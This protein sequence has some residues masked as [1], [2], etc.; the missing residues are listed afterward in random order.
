M[1]RFRTFLIIVTLSY[2]VPIASRAWA[3]EATEAPPSAE[4][5]VAP[6]NGL[7]Q[8]SP[9]PTYYPLRSS[10]SVRSAPTI[11]ALIVFTITGQ[12]QAL[13]AMG[14]V[15]DSNVDAYR[16][17]GDEAPLARTWIKVVTSTGQTGFVSLADVITP[18]QLPGQ[19][20][21]LRKVSLFEGEIEAA[22][23]ASGGAVPSGIYAHGS[24][25]DGD[26][27]AGTNLSNFLTSKFLLW[28]E[29]D[30]LHFVQVV[31]PTEPLIYEQQKDGHPLELRGH[32]YVMLQTYKSSKDS[33]LMGY[34][35]KLLWLSAT[36]AQFDNYHFCGSD[37]YKPVLEMLKTYAGQRPPEMSKRGL[38]QIPE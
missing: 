9:S 35:D 12:G 8:R 13:K 33:V 36:G 23:E 26:G 14:M 5:Q 31:N 20:E 17:M 6:Y 10:T 21:S 11:T 25:C 29:G 24:S 1:S 2:L 7:L 4:S 18:K 22:K 16:S 30:K 27:L 37:A 32:G 3:Q 34:K 19:K 28:Q 15:I 38:K